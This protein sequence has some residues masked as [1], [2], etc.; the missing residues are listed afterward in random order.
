MSDVEGKS[1]KSTLREYFE[2]LLIALILVNFAW[3]FVLQAFVIPSG[4]MIDNLLIGDHIIVNKFAYGPGNSGAACALFPFREVRRGDIV[5]FR[6]PSDLSVNF[7]KRV[8]G[9]PGDTI[10]I[11]DKIVYVDGKRLDEPY[12]IHVDERVIPDKPLLTMKVRDQLGPIV[13]PEGHY[14][15][16]GDN[17]DESRDSRYWGTVSRGLIKG[18][19][20]MV[21]WSYAEP[22]APANATFRERLAEL[23]GVARHFLS[24]TRWDRTFFVVD[25]EYHYHAERYRG[26]RGE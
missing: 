20:F 8:I 22:P 16:L 23:A 6:Y 24:R 10:E 19:A 17:R 3:A 12:V 11:R 1:A 25:S 14:F 7:V 13:I 5:V 26:V 2:A 4:S 18:R 9:L 21:Y 15:M